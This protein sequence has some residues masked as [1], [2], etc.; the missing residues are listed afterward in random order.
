M[1]DRGW[2]LES[3]S[4]CSDR[5]DRNDPDRSED[6]AVSAIYMSHGEYTLLP[7]LSP[8]KTTYDY[9]FMP[10]AR[11][12]GA[13]QIQSLG[14]RV[15]RGGAIMM[16]FH[17]PTAIRRRAR[18]LAGVVWIR[19]VAL[20]AVGLLALLTLGDVASL[21]RPVAQRDFEFEFEFDRR[22]SPPRSSPGWPH[23]RGPS[24]DAVS[25][26][27]GLANFWP[28]EGPPVLWQ[29]PLGR[30]YSGFSV[31]GHRAFTQTQTLTAQYV[32]CLD[33]DTG[34][35]I[36][37]HRYGW[38]YE[39]GGMYPGPRATPTW[40]EGRVYF[41]GP[42]GLVGC[43][44]ESDGKP[45]WK[46]DVN[47]KFG[48]RGTGFGYSCSPL[49]ED[50][51]VILPVGGQRASVVALD[52]LDGSTVWAAGD[53]SASY[54]SA[55]PITFRGQRCVVAFLKNALA[56]FDLETGRQ[57]CLQVYS[58]GYDEHAAAPLYDEPYLM[59]ARAFRSGAECYRLEPEHSRA[60]HDSLPRLRLKPVWQ[61]RELSSDTASSVLL[62]RH[63]YGF[64]LRDVQAKAH[65]PSRGE[66]KCLEL[67]TGEVL[68]KTDR[69]GHATVL[70]ADGKLVLFNDQGELILARAN[71]DRYDE[72]ARTIVFQGEICWTAPALDRGRLYLRS[73]TRAACVYVGRPDRLDVRQR[74]TARPTSSIPQSPRLNLARFVGGEREYAFDPADAGELGRWFAFSLVGV[75]GVAAL[76]AATVRLPVGMKW[77]SA[78]PRVGQGVFWSA[79][80]ILGVFGTPVFNRWT[81]SFV[82]TWPVCLFVAHQVTLNTVVWANRA[83][84]LK[85]APW[86]ALLATCLLVGVC[87]VYFL[88]CRRLS[89]A[90][91]WTFLLG[92][93]PSWPIAVPAAYQFQRGHRPF[94]NFAWTLLA[95]TAFYWSAGAWL[96]WQA[97]RFSL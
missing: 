84:S 24:H 6:P 73:P 33:A 49:L 16:A 12:S 53:E 62:D 71:P 19:L 41:A 89:L 13:T 36:W 67:T 28:P 22:E 54:C 45:L 83:T 63:V 60:T 69:V 26:E 29:R 81:G 87:L 75:L 74:R 47:E 92:F 8:N 97:G 76:V 27:T 38:P 23:R 18:A 31:V 44:R 70:A 48:G 64:D 1:S 61:S 82:F 3:F 17:R 95:F 91:E 4:C 2:T 7:P 40:H 51:K 21:F 80:F 46:V 30:G 32:V 42:T 88:V 35:Q 5:T 90:T 58:R 25:P 66:F 20:A 10:Y 65:R 39:P 85:R 77:P 14:N 93:L 50:G 34:E 57:L 52:A 94:R 78:G 86:M 9:Q 37:Q 59:V 15:A 96:I 43:L 79:A 72:L 68:W 55:L 56:L 11:Y